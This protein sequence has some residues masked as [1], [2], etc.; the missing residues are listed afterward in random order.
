MVLAEIRHGVLRLPAAPLLEVIDAHCAERGASRV[1]TL[2]EAGKRC[3]WRA[4]TDGTISPTVAR[5]LCDLIGC[6]PRELYGDAWQEA[7]TSRVYSPPPITLQPRLDAGPLVDAIEARVQR[8]VEQ[9]MPLTD[10]GTARG[11]AMQRVFRGDETLKRAFQRA[12]QRGWVLLEAAEQ[13]CDA[14][15]W[16]PRHL[17][18]DAYDEAALAGLPANFDVWE[19]VA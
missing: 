8:V 12:R 6:D 18:A 2:G 13:L 5:R 9:L 15:G 3:Y 1:R 4:R 17:W 14:F 7:A 10:S 19:G 11:E 16:H